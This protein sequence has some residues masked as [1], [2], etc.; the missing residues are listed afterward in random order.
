MR[1]KAFQPRTNSTTGK[2]N[3]LHVLQSSSASFAV[4]CVKI[5]QA[6]SYRMIPFLDDDTS[7]RITPHAATYSNFARRTTPHASR[8]VRNLSAPDNLARSDVPSFD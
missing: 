5:R 4:F 1:R 8:S 3:P 2:A 6:Y 7:R